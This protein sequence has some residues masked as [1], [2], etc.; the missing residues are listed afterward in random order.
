MQ[1]ILSQGV[2]F[3]S[4]LTCLLYGY[5]DFIGLIQ[6][7][8]ESI[9]DE[10]IVLCR[11]IPRVRCDSELDSNLS[12]DRTPSRPAIARSLTPGMTAIADHGAMF[13]AALIEAED[14]PG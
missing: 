2:V 13:G 11:H 9:S 4:P 3:V 6:P 7:A 8:F 5:F 14:V 10:P 1:G 12:S